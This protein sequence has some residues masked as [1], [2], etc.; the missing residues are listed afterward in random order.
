[1]SIPAVGI[2]VFPG[3]GCIRPV[4]LGR[5]VEDRGF[6]ALFFPEHLHMPVERT[7]EFPI[8]IPLP[9]IYKRNL[10]PFMAFAAISGVTSR[11]TFGTGIS[12]VAQRDPILLAKTI[13]TLDHLCEGRFVLGVGAGWNVEEMKNHGVDPRHRWGHVEDHVRAMRTIWTEDIATYHGQF[14]DFDRIWSWPKPYENRHVPVLVGGSPASFQRILRWADGWIPAL[15]GDVDPLL[16]GIDQLRKL[17]AARDPGVE[18]DITVAVG[19]GRVLSTDEFRRLS[20]ARVTR[21]LLAI[22][23][24]SYQETVEALD[25]AASVARIAGSDGFGRSASSSSIRSCVAS[26]PPEVS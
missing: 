2:Q 19:Y 15:D 25:K 9:E 24:G 11:L 16:A 21:I 4:D 22:N 13:A 14:T 5:A 8:P 17:G 7:V 23:P 1:M 3:D 20:A 26:R 12:L 18:L 6:E 10:D